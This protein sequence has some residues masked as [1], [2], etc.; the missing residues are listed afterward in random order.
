MLREMQAL[1]KRLQK[2]VTALTETARGHL[3]NILANNL[4][5][6]CPYSD[7]VAEPKLIINGL[8]SLAE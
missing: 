4:A 1:L 7:N 2:E 5:A 6:F 8:I 3:C